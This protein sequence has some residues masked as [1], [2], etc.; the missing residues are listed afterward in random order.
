MDL[1]VLKHVLAL[2]E[3]DRSGPVKLAILELERG[4]AAE[5]RAARSSARTPA[6]TRSC[7]R[8]G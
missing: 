7:L 5:L 2:R 1:A 3:H 8:R 4:C 6:V